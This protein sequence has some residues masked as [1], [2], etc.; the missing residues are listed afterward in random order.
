MG[1]AH[2]Q[3]TDWKVPGRR[4]WVLLLFFTND[5]CCVWWSLGDAC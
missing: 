1:M 3:K 2:F 4:R 5:G